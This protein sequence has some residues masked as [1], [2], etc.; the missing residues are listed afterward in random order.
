LELEETQM[1]Y[2]AGIFTYIW[3]IFGVNVGVHLPAPW[4]AYGYGMS[5]FP[6]TKSIIFQA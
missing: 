2:G 3:A 1:L 4:V 5:S 6:L